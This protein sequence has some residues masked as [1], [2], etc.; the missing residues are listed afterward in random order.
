MHPGAR[1]CKLLIL[2]DC[3]KFVDSVPHSYGSRCLF[4]VGSSFIVIGFSLA[5]QNGC[6]NYDY[7]FHLIP[8]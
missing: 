2:A 8:F 7:D 5:S 4:M 3:K 1:S 6:K